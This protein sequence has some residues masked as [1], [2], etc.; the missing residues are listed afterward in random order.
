MF[1]TL[2]INNLFS[3][4][5]LAFAFNHQLNEQIHKVMHGEKSL[6]VV[7]IVQLFDF[8]DS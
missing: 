6:I 7:G 8:A 4:R 5:R 1:A 3:G 2:G